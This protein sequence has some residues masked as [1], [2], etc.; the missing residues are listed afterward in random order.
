VKA[1][2]ARGDQPAIAAVSSASDYLALPFEKRYEVASQTFPEW[3]LADPITF[4]RDHRTYGWGCRVHDCNAELANS[5]IKFLCNAHDHEYRVVSAQLSIDEFTTQ[6]KPCPCKYN[7][8][9]RA[10]RENCRVC[11]PHREALIRGFC[12]AHDK[13]LRQARKRG[14]DEKAWLGAQV[15]FAAHPRCTVLHC[16]HDGVLF[17]FRGEGRVKICRSHYE[18][19]RRYRGEKDRATAVTAWTEWVN[20][21]AKTRRMQPLD[22]RGLVALS[23][24]PRRLQCEIRYAIHRHALTVRRAHWRPRHIQLIVD[25]LAQAGVETLNDPMLAEQAPA[26]KTLEIRRIWTDLPIAARSL[27]LTKYDAKEAGWFDPVIVGAAPFQ[28]SQGGESRRK[29]WDL[30]DVSQRWLRDLLWDHLE[31]LATETK[32]P[33]AGCVY[34]R[35]RD[36]RLLSKALRQLREDEGNRPELLDASDA[37]A[38]KDLWDL[39]HREQ[40]PILESNT[41]SPP[42]LSALS[43]FLHR[44]H[45]SGMRIVLL[46]GRKRGLR[47]PTDSFVLAFPQY[48]APQ[49]PPN[50]RPISDDDFR[51]LTNDASLEQLD[52]SDANNVGLAD[53]WFT[54]AYQGGRIGETLALRLGCIAMIGDAQ[55]YLWRDISKVNVIDY[56]MPCHFPVYQRLLQRQETTRKKLRARYAD[57][58]AGLNKRQRAALEAEWDRT[59]PLFPSTTKNPDLRLPLSQSYFREKFGAWIDQLGLLGITTHRTRA[60]LATSLLNN[61]APA[62]LVRQL[63][64]HFSEESLAH[65]ARYSDDNVVRHL[66]QVW[67][68]GPGMD[69]P[70]KVLLTP[71]VASG[72][73]SKAAVTNR[74]DLSVIPVEHGLCRYGPVV[75]GSACPASKNCSSGPNGPCPH[76]VL[77]GADLSYWER[78]RDAAYHFAEGAPSEDARDYILSEWKPWENVLAGL[79]EALAELGLLDAAERLDLRSPMQDFFHPLFSTGLPLDAL[80]GKS[81]TTGHDQSAEEAK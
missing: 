27:T 70:G 9:G 59:M 32:R 45:P 8:W 24:L 2:T 39:W 58:L 44:T 36:I 56:G 38:F 67:T 31:Y 20:G 10:R 53:I 66:H 72:L 74:I 71:V 16:V 35:I 33:A 77:T 19:W 46:F 37:R 80:P 21:E 62:A 75:G 13:L 28:G 78:K 30:S 51:L 11:G 1:A 12:A 34:R 41:S 4:P 43:E 65:Y 40:V 52:T 48:S 69:Q 55:P 64:G 3:L 73:G 17:N 15:P 25:V 60:T 23:H 6:A 49:E 79:R 18:V 26:Y 61:G 81:S 22:G 63:L 47:G 14:D 76:F 5:N 68:A 42:T 50:P 57:D 7:D 29:V 54:H